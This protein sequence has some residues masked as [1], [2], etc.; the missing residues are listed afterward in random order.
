MDNRTDEEYIRDFFK[1]AEES[2]LES[3]DDEK[4]K[5]KMFMICHEF[6]LEQRINE[7]K[8]GTEDRDN[9]LNVFLKKLLTINS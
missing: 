1:R 4:F 3:S 2:Y 8:E 6:A 5:R 7:I 9:T